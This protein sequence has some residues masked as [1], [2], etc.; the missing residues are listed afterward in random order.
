MA[1]WRNLGEKHRKCHGFSRNHPLHSRPK[2]LNQVIDTCTAL[3]I[4]QGAESFLKFIQ[5]LFYLFQGSFCK[6]SIS[7]DKNHS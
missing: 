6:V 1:T 2:A 7:N 4:G 5:N 3:T